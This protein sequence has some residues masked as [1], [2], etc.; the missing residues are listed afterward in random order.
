[1]W[2]AVAIAV[3]VL[4]VLFV[5]LYVAAAI[6]YPGGTWEEPSRTG[7]SFLFNYYCDLMRPVALNGQPNALGAALAEWGQLILALALG[8]FFAVAPLCFGDRKKLTR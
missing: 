5:T 6:A 1:M 3:P 7:H 8:P 2:R 4:L